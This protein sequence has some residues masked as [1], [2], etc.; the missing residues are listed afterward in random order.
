MKNDLVKKILDKKFHCVFVSPHEDDAILS[1][2]TLLSKLSGKVDVTV[3]NVFTKAHKKPYTLAARKF[4]MFTGYANAEELY[5][6]RRK[7]DKEAFSSLSVKITYLDLEDALFRKK[8]KKSF[9]GK[10]IPEFDHYYPTYQL[11][12]VKNIV[13][14]DPAPAALEK[15]LERFKDKKYLIFAPFGVGN[16]ADHRIARLATEKVFD[17]YILYSDFPYNTRLHSVGT[18]FKNGEE[19]RIESNMELKDPLIKAYKTQF[20]GLFPNSIIPTHQEVYF[21]NQKL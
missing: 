21:S 3:V 2:G 14:T 11:H 19:F 13:Q 18:A 17:R 5:E 16:H 12:I 1:C 7:E 6:A 8:E 4:L 15:H 9:L 10:L 20:T